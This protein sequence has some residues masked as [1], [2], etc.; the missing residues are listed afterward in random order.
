MEIGP[1]WDKRSREQLSWSEN[2]K[3][4]DLKKTRSRNRLGT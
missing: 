4:M 3:K 1:V 2:T